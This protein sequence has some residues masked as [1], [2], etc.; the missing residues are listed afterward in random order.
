[1]LAMML[2]FGFQLGSGKIFAM[3]FYYKNSYQFSFQQN[4]SGLTITELF[5]HSGEFND[6]C[7]IDEINKYCDPDCEPGSCID[8]TKCVNT[9]NAICIDPNKGYQLD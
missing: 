8:D 6:D 1:M 5:Y 9:D 4:I 2:A 7:D 3:D